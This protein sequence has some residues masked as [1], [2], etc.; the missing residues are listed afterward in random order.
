MKNTDNNLR[1]GTRLHKDHKRGKFVI[2]IAKIQFLNL[3]VE[4]QIE[5]L[6]FFGDLRPRPH[7]SGYF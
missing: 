4:F 3:L 6:S 2:Q 1:R 5:F 7:V